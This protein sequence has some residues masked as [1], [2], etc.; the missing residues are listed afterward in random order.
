MITRLRLTH[1]KAWRELKIR[2]ATVTGIFGAN[3]AG[4]SS[5]IQ[6]LLL[7]KQTREATDR[8]IVLD[9]GGPESLANLGSFREVAHGRNTDTGIS[10]E[11][12]WTLPKLLRI[13]TQSADGK[14]VG[15]T[16]REMA[17]RC[18]VGLSGPQPS[19]TFFTRNL[20]YQ[21]DDTTFALEPSDGGR[22]RAYTLNITGGQHDFALK[23]SQ[24]RPFRIPPPSR[25][26][27]SRSRSGGPTRT[28]IFSASWSCHTRA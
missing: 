24:G 11:L 28:P 15:F 14:S 4:K 7:L 5:L 20:S 1:F 2:F 9:F 18:A 17:I 3:S 21:F 6:F 12:G 8:R 19:S 23:R 10:W 25:L 13:A 22:R 16:G 26:T 27:R